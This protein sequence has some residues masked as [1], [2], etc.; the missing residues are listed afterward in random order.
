[1]YQQHLWIECVRMSEEHD[2][3]LFV[4]FTFCKDVADL[5][6]K[7]V[8]GRKYIRSMDGW[9]LRVWAVSVFVVTEIVGK[10]SPVWKFVMFYTLEGAHGVV[11]A[12]NFCPELKRYHNKLWFSLILIAHGGR[13]LRSANNSISLRMLWWDAWLLKVLSRCRI[14][15]LIICT[16][17]DHRYSQQ[18]NK[19]EMF[20]V[21]N[22]VLSAHMG[23][24]HS[25]KALSNFIKT[26]L[27][28]G[29]SI[30]HSN[31]S[32]VC[33]LSYRWR[34]NFRTIINSKQLTFI[35]SFIKVFHLD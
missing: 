6:Q 20:R 4:R 21:S 28:C 7:V 25:S 22:E 27:S 33:R 14:A 32:K 8:A 1:M 24:F 16:G 30:K 3:L 5:Y 13:S 34:W 26:H 2:F 19:I 17:T 18:T 31:L 15:V 35:H 12:N 29:R 23:R 10:G 11:D 9:L